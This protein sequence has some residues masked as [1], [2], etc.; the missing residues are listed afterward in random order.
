MTRLTLLVLA[1]TSTGCAT[2]VHGRSQDVLVLSEP[3]GASIR[4]NGRDVGSTPTTV[5]MRRR[6]RAELV[7]AK[8]GYEPTTIPVAR[9]ESAWMFGNVILLNPLAAQGMD[10]TGQWAAS[11]A[12][13]FVGAMTLDIV[14]GGGFKRPPVVTV[15]LAPLPA[16]PPSAA[17][18]TASSTTFSTA[19][20]TCASFCASSLAT[21]SCASQTPPGCWPPGALPGCRAT[22]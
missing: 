1:L 3:S 9:H 17:F 14:T 2:M 4:L 20:S 19:F 11:A 13:W 22:C 10:S 6:G 21:A 8:A 16:H 12:A 18:F 5:A 15:T 7:V